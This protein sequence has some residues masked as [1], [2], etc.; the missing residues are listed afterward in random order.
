M[1]TKIDFYKIRCQSNNKI[2]IWD[3]YNDIENK[4]LKLIKYWIIKF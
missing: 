1:V 2:F 4:S 3:R